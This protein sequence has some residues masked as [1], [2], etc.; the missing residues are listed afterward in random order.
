M[1]SPKQGGEWGVLGG[2][3]DPIHRGHLNLAGNICQKKRLNGVLFI[4][5]YKHPLKKQ[6]FTAA[7]SDRAAMLRLALKGQAKLQ[8]C[9]IEREQDLS[10]YTIDT[11]HALKKRFPA[12]RFHF[13]IGLDLVEQLESWHRADELLHETSFLAGSRPGS[14]M[15]QA[16]EKKHLEFIE[17]EELDISATDIRK[18]VSAGTTI[19]QISRLVPDNVVEYIF[20][21]G[22]YR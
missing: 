5:A 3:F 9:E 15:K 21:K 14:Q 2:S 17:M 19:H 10:G 13:I 12:A 20:G 7:Y 6:D 4:P 1:R 18:Q 22:L 11:L 8:V 16:D